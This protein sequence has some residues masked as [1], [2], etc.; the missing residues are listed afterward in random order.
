MKS[1]A[2]FDPTASLRLILGS[3]AAVNRGC[4]ECTIESHSG[5]VKFPGSP[6]HHV[7]FPVTRCP[8]I[9]I[10]IALLYF[11]NSRSQGWVPLND[12]LTA[13]TPH[14][15]KR[16]MRPGGIRW[17][18]TFGGAAGLL[19]LGCLLLPAF[20]QGRGELR[21][22]VA[23]LPATLD[24]ATALEGVTPLISRQ[25]FETLVQYHEI[26]SDVVA[27][28]AVQWGVSKDGLI[29]TFLLRDG[30]RFH[31]GSPLT[32]HHIVAS[33]ERHLSQNHPL[34]PDLPV[35][36]PRLLR[37]LPGVIR[38]VRAPDPKTFQITLRLPYAALLTVL[39]HPG[40]A[41][42]HSAPGQGEV[43][44]WVG[45]GPF[46]FGEMGPGRVVLEANPGYWR[47]P[48]RVDRIVFYE[49]G[50]EEA[51]R[52][53][54]EGRRLDLWFPPRPPL[55]S[56][57]AVSLPSWRVGILALQTER[58][59]LGKKK[60]RQAV[61]AALDPA[62]LSSALG[63][64]A[65]PLQS[66]LPPGVWGRREGPPILGGDVLFARRLLGEAGFP[67]GIS[68]T[69]MLDDAER[70]VDQVKVAEAIRESLA[71][72]GIALQLRVEPAPVVR[73]SSQNGD[74]EWLLTEAVVDGGDP[75]LFLYPLSTSE[76]A[77]KGPNAF[78]LSFYRNSRLDD[79]LV[80]AS[81]LAFRPERLKLYQ[82]AQG[83]LADELP[84]IPLYVQLHWAVVR[85]E[86]R[87]LRLHP[88]G[89]HR[90]DRVWVEPDPGSLSR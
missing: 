88:S 6:L 30:V 85:P 26:G 39:A 90:L 40:F 24:P 67:Q 82:R 46:R 71:R 2:F 20:G 11:E 61:A 13:R 79:L 72:A 14:P 63:R 77:T 64:A 35:V 21:V 58:E 74:H 48:A 73:Q 3:D 17:R 83:I 49:M 10:A 38:E 59:P 42:V 41:V 4:N 53:E 25:V 36:W 43:P 23:S 84:W 51:A 5:D 47:G 22:G 62:L 75:H 32:A 27:G 37:G 31:D 80:R 15:Y 1:F 66:L 69:L 56:E 18:C 45:T 16:S 44:Q 87:G 70:L 12:H 89:I 33:F 76:G 78:N 57:W 19:L 60:V 50:V 52:A 81:Q 8:A 29:W 7:A 34:H 9:A 54:L 68:G 65:V 86:V 28:L 55:K